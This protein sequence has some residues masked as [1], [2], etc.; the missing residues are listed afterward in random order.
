MLL[1]KG[2][3]HRALG[4]LR[5]SVTLRRQEDVALEELSPR[6]FII[7]LMDKLPIADIQEQQPEGRSRSRKATA[8]RK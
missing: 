4:R 3:D 2:Y 8:D 1:S 6:E 5:Q 7:Q